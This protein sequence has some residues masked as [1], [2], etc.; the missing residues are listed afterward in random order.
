MPPPTKH[1]GDEY[2][3]FST[4]YSAFVD[5]LFNAYNTKQF[6]GEVCPASILL[7]YFTTQLRGAAF[8][9]FARAL[10]RS[11]KLDA[12]DRPI[13]PWSSIL[14]E[15]EQYVRRRLYNVSK[16]AW[17]RRENGNSWGK[18]PDKAA[19]NMKKEWERQLDANVPS[20][21]LSKGLFSPKDAIIKN[22]SS[23]ILESIMLN[24]EDYLRYKI[25][26]SN[27]ESLDPDRTNR[28]LKLK[29]GA[30]SK[31]GKYANDF[32]LS[33]Y[34]SKTTNFYSDN[35][36]KNADDFL[37]TY[38]K[39]ALKDLSDEYAGSFFSGLNG[40]S[41]ESNNAEQ[42]KYSSY[43]NLH[44]ETGADLIDSA[45]PKSINLADAMGDGGLVENAIESGNRMAEIAKN[46]P[47]GNYRSK[48]ASIMD[49]LNKLAIIASL[50][51][52]RQ[53]M[54]KINIAIRKFNGNKIK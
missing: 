43:Y 30:L 19:E 23:P 53:S 9:G 40:Q 37:N 42:D 8:D 39:D 18:T 33:R 25:I 35:M 16:N 6:V 52:D 29:L 46:T 17:S 5:T 3:K 11:C 1:V 32:D 45:H 24:D 34:I 10:R 44:D 51:G 47:S 26:R 7:W 50:S 48:H 20:W 22:S 13:I 4:S 31:Y 54:K 15:S 28:K 49:R 38:M 2:S 36:K 14:E 12:E 21:K 41:S 27:C